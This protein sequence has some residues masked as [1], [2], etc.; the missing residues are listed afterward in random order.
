MSFDRSVF[1]WYEAIMPQAV[2]SLRR[3]ANLGHT[4]FLNP[5][6]GRL[7]PQCADDPPV[8]LATS[9]AVSRGW[10]KTTFPRDSRV[11]S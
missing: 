10:N 6:H 11:F 4:A 1:D 8:A 3:L 7:P 9:L 5:R 2:A